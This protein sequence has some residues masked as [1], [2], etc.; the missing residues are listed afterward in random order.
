MLR[1][2]KILSSTT[3]ATTFQVSADDLSAVFTLRFSEGENPFDLQDFERF[4]CPQSL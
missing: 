2:A 4:R 1:S 3:R